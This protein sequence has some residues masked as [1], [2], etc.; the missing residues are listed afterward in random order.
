[1]DDLLLRLAKAYPSAVIYTFRMEHKLFCERTP[2]AAKREI[3]HQIEA[4]LRNPVTETFNESLKYMS[5]EDK[6]LD[7]HIKNIINTTSESEFQRELDVCFENIFDD[8]NMRK[9][10]VNL[11]EEPFRRALMA[12]KGMNCESICFE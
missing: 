12:I 6:V 10:S 7:Y 3:V 5:L 8:K 11:V 2:I 4:T 1:M 9:A